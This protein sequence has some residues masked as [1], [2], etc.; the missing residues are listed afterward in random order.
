MAT[1]VS[2]VPEA[3]LLPLKEELTHKQIYINPDRLRSGRGRSQAFGIIRRWSYRPWVSRNCWLRPDLWELL[4]DFAAKHVHIP[5]D[6]VQVNDNYESKPH[7]DVGNRG[8]SYIIGFGDYTGGELVLD[9]SGQEEIIDTKNRGYL[10][11]GSQIRHWNKPIVGRKFSLVFFK[12][13]WPRFWPEEKGKPSYEIVQ[14]EGKKWVRIND[15]DGSVWEARGGTMNLVTP[16][17]RQ[18]ERVGKVQGFGG[19]AIV[20]S[21]PQT[22]DQSD[23][24]VSASSS[25]V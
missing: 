8:D 5:W 12:I 1:F 4:L 6:A 7:K 19:K 2:I 14:K 17:T 16:A 3:D 15:C 18:L 10:F 24:S 9:V 21:D 13:E 23:R 11:N 22:S 25:P 20:R